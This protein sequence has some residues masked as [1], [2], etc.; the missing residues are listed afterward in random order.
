MSSWHLSRGEN[1]VVHNNYLCSYFNAVRIFHIIMSV[2]HNIIIYMVNV[3][4]KPPASYKWTDWF[5]ESI[6]WSSRLQE[7]HQPF[8]RSLWNMSQINEENQKLSTWNWLDLRRLRPWPIL[9]KLSPDTILILNLDS[10]VSIWSRWTQL[11]W[12]NDKLGKGVF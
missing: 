2:S 1:I 11:K 8:L 3:M 7:K 12:A 9:P 5:W 6:G 10:T 4:G